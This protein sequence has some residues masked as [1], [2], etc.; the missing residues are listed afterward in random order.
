MR[1]IAASGTGLRS[2]HLHCLNAGGIQAL[3][4]ASFPSLELLE[5]GLDTYDMKIDMPG[6][7]ARVRQR[8]GT[9]LQVKLRLGRFPD[10]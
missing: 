6:L 4:A 1:A 9:H 5:L 3:L 7:E 2:L 8:F 10:S